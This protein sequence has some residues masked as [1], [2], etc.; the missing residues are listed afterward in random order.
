MP[1]ALPA[2]GPVAYAALSCG[3]FLGLGDKLFAI[4]D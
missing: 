4:P 3:D 2:T 1:D